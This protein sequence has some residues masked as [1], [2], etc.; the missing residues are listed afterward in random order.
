MR[1]A[2]HIREEVNSPPDVRAERQR[3]F[4]DVIARYER[5]E[6][7][8]RHSTR[9]GYKAMLRNHIEPAWGNSLLRDVAP[10]KVRTWLNGLDCAPRYRGHIHGLMRVLFKFAMLWEYLPI[11]ENPMA[12][13]SIQ[14]SSKRE[15]D[16][17][18]ISMQQFWDLL[19]LLREPVRTAVIVAGCLGLRC[20][21]I[22]ALKWSD[23]DFHELRVQIQRSF[24]NGRVDDVKTR[25]S[26]KKLP[27]H[28][29]LAQVLLQWRQKSEFKKE[30]DWVFAS[31][32]T[33]G[34]QPYFPHMLQYRVLRVVG[35]D[36]GMDFNL[37]WHTFRH[38]F[39]TWHDERGT[40]LSVQ[41]DLMRHADIRTTMQVYGDV[42]LDRL[43]KANS[44]LVETLL[45]R[46]Q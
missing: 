36:L 38:S 22:F 12:L 26:K 11:A 13:F 29:D 19:P 45:R 27:L 33:A 30:D 46:P 5:E 42:T 9:R 16:P 37:G 2:S 28:E 31:P 20:S 15:D 10:Y 35:K 24:V 41:R 23:F 1:A 34:T 32:Q 4:S 40:E 39:K 43:R 7:P 44:G 21:E 3:R 17:R 25:Y 18:I 6:M 8:K 14:A